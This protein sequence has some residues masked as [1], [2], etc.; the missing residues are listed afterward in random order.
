MSDTL[1]FSRLTLR[2]DASLAP[3]T[4][5]LAPSDTGAAMAMDHRLMWTL[6]PPD[7]RRAREE[8]TREA[9]APA[10]GAFLWRKLDDG[11][12]YML[13]PA[14]VAESP[15]FKIESKPFEPRF[16]PGDRLAFDLRVNATVERK[17]GMENG[18][19]LR[20]RRD[21][22]LDRLLAE[23]AAGA[24]RATRAQRR[25]PA[26]EAAARDWL[27][28]RAEDGGFRLIAS[29]LVAYR[30]EAI[31]RDGPARRRDRAKR[32]GEN[33]ADPREAAFG[34]LDLEGLLEVERPDA[35]LQRLRVGFGH[36]KAFGCGLMLLRRA[37]R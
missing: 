15:L 24:D 7:I 14:P 26:A 8:R 16:A 20:Q 25:L 31:P 6:M 21:V 5:V 28:A 4:N 33:G 22:T 12:Y 27:A 2:P 3:L 13:G 11:Q 1:Y 34:I 37:P 17:I 9:G 23:E 18:K 10:D 30:T 29:R 35:F 32:R 36:A 19:A